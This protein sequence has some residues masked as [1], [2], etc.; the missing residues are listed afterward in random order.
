MNPSCYSISDHLARDLAQSVANVTNH[1]RSILAV[2]VE[3]LKADQE[4]ELV[5]EFSLT[6]LENTL[7]VFERHY[8]Q[9]IVEN[10]EFEVEGGAVECKTSSVAEIACRLHCHFAKVPTTE[11]LSVVGTIRL[12]GCGCNNKQWCLYY[13]DMPSVG[14]D[15]NAASKRCRKLDGDEDDLH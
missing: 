5:N 3:N 12:F 10:F 4:T 14:L 15:E 13:G 8:L 11:S 1:H 9:I 2:T 6:W 7:R